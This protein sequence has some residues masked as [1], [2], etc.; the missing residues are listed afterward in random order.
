[1]V[2]EDASSRSLQR[3][4]DAIIPAANAIAPENIMRNPAMIALG[5]S[6]EYNQL[7]VA[8]TMHIKDVHM[9]AR[10]DI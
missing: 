10:R 6:I 3:A 9:G 5:I 8:I 2:G 7:N 4:S 1:L